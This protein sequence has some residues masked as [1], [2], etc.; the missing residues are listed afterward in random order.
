MLRESFLGA[1][2]FSVVVLCGLFILVHTAGCQRN[3]LGGYD[4]G[5]APA[6]KTVCE[7]NRSGNTVCKTQ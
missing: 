2:W 1:F 6:G 3:G 5:P 7:T 4:V